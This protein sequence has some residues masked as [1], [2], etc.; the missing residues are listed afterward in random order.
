MPVKTIRRDG[1]SFVLLERADFDRLS[2]L[3]STQSKIELPKPNKE[4][5]FDA[6][7][8]ARA[9]IARGIIADRIAAGLSQRELAVQAGIRPQTLAC[10]EAAT[11]SPSVKTIER[12]DRALKVAS[13]LARSPK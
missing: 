2:G 11:Q 12:I 7:E 6:V 3:A 1:K 9:T 13:K 5:N 10:I 8:F 4:G